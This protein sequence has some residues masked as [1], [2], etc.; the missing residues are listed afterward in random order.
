MLAL[1]FGA[2][3]VVR[4]LHDHHFVALVGDGVLGFGLL[5]LAVDLPHLRLALDQRRSSWADSSNCTTI[6]PS[7][8]GLPFSRQ[9]HNLQVGCLGGDDL[10]PT[11]RS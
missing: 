11:S 7:A 1:Q 2:L 9:L 5:D 8:I 6:A 4:R 10:P 3:E